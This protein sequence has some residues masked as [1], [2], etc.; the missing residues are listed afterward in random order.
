MSKRAAPKLAYTLQIQLGG[1]QVRISKSRTAGPKMHSQI[2][3][4]GKRPLPVSPDV[5]R[6]QL[7]GDLMEFAAG[8]QARYDNTGAGT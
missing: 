8:L 5:V 4:D 1:L 6:K 7:E 3:S 2:N